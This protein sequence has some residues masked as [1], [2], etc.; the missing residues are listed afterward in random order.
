MG[1][2]SAISV[3]NLVGVDGHPIQIRRSVTVPVTIA[4][5]T[6]S[7]EFVIANNITA[8]GIL[9]MDFLENHKC[10]VNIA[11]KEIILEQSNSC[12]SCCHLK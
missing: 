5:T 9:G 8:D 11:K 4:E 2:I 1:K 3:G 6:F 7:Q 12:N 10:V